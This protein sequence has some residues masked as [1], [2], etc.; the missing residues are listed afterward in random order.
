MRRQ[1]IQ[2]IFNDEWCENGHIW[3]NPFGTQR[4]LSLGVVLKYLK[5][6]TLRRISRLASNKTG[7]ASA[8]KLIVNRP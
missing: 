2:R 5:W 3:P 1:D 6:I 4:V 7:Y 8:I